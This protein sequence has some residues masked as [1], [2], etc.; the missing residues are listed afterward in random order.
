MTRKMN[1]ILDRVLRHWTRETLLGR[2][3]NRRRFRE[4]HPMVQRGGVQ[5][6]Q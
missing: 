2:N 4:R 3:L 1:A 5:Q 6:T